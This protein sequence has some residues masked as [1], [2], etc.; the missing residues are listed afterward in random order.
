MLGYGWNI[1]SEKLRHGVLGKL[2][3]FVLEYGVYFDCA[4]FG[5]VEDK[6]GVVHIVI[7]IGLF[8]I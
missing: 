3:G 2:D 1:Y 8:I 5:F 4:I 7:S 6:F